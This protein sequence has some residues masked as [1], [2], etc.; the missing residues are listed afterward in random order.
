MDIAKKRAEEKTI[1]EKMMRVYCRGQKHGAGK[2][3]LCAGCEELLA[4]ANNRTSHCPY[5]ESKTFCSKCPTH[6]YKPEKREQIRSVMRY[7]GPRML[8]HSPVLVLKHAL[9]P[10][11]NRPAQS[12]S[13]P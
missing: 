1:M 8:L 3:S 2:G 13:K 12:E 4:Y 7:A 11:Q 5:M 9:A 10:K 6:C